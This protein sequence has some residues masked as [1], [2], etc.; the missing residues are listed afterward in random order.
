MT[1]TLKRPSVSNLS[2]NSLGNIEESQEYYNA[3]Q[4]VTVEVQ[5]RYERLKGEH[6]KDIE[7]RLRQQFENE[8]SLKNSFTRLSSSALE[9]RSTL[10]DSIEGNKF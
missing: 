5:E 3:V 4:K 9:S 2:S 7:K 1:D 10:A 6:E 8:Y